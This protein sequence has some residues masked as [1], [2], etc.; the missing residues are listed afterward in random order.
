MMDAVE[1]MKRIA[2]NNAKP[3]YWEQP[4]FWEK[5]RRART[6]LSDPLFSAFLAS[7]PKPKP[8]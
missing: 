8:A 5:V 4:E 6:G 2:E 3:E 7:L 1:L